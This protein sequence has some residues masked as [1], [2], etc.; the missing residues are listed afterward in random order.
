MKTKFILIFVSIFGLN[1]TLIKSQ[2]PVDFSKI[3]DQRINSDPSV[4]W[5]QFG[6]GG[7]GNNYYIYWHPTDPNTV[8][9]G[10]N[11]LNA[12]RS[13]DGG[14]TYQGILDYDGKG[15]R[16]FERGPIMITT[17]EFSYQNPDFGFCTTEDRN[18]L[19]RTNDKGATWTLTDI[20]KDYFENIF[21]NTI[22]VDPTDGNIW[23]A[24]SGSIHDCNHYFHTHALP[25]GKNSV[26]KNHKARIWKSIDKGNSWTNITPTGINQDA[27]IT[28]I[29]VHPG[30]PS[31]VF[32]ATTYG[33]Y[34]S[35]NGG[36]S[37]TLKTKTGMDNDIIRS[38]D[39][40][41][42]KITN[43]LT[44]YAIDLVKYIP[45]G[46]SLTYNGGIYKSTD[47]GESW[48]NINNNMPLPSSII[49]GY[50]V[51]RSL[52]IDALSGWFGITSTV[53]EATYSSIPTQLLH[54]VSVI[55]VNPSDPNKI[56]VINNYKSQYTFSGGMMWRSDNGGDSWFVTFRNGT[57]WE[58]RDYAVWKSRNNPTS[59]NIT[60]RAQKEWEKRDPYD[61]K[62]GAVAEFNCT[63]DRIMFQVAKVVCISDDNGDTWVENDEQEATPNS[64]NWVGAGNS[65]MPGADIIQDPR[66]DNFIYLTSGENSIW[67]TTSDGTNVRPYAQAVHKIN[68]PNRK[69]P[70]ECSV[71]TIAI[72]PADVNTLYSV[73]FRQMYS[74]L[75]M[76][77]TDAGEN[78]KQYGKVFDFPTNVSNPKLHQQSL[79]IDPDDRK[80]YCCVPYS[81]VNDKVDTYAGSFIGFGVY[82]STDNGVTF[83]QLNN[84]LPIVTDN[85]LNVQQLAL[86]PNNKGVVYAAVSTNTKLNGGLFRLDKGS[87]TWVKVSLPSG[88]AG[89]NNLLFAH[90][91]MYISC[92]STSPTYQSVS[93]GGVWCSEDN[94]KNWTQIF[95]CFNANHIAVA[96]YDPKVILI[97]IPSINMINPGVYRSLNGGV[98]WSKINTGNLQSDRLNALKI[99]LYQRGVYWCSTYGAGYYKGIDTVEMMGNQSGIAPI[100]EN[101]S[102]NRLHTFPN[103]TSGK[104]SM[105]F[106]MQKPGSL[107][108]MVMN[109]LGAILENKNMPNIPSGT[110]N[111]EISL[112]K[113]P[114]GIYFLCLKEGTQ[115][116]YSKINKL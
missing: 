64:E 29:L 75:L 103:P 33:L 105:S 84:G 95:P 15:Y 8:F 10:P 22:E 60:Y 108:Y 113:Y 89:V 19:Y 1:T 49:S 53:A 62:S 27:Q 55:R 52:Y 45:N 109:D 61:Q 43:K 80:F 38:I 110:F 13:T 37:W 115:M 69:D 34:K 98:S 18:F 102:L 58:G 100:V 24:G 96:N 86:D 46:N 97:S 74:G 42:D 20:S 26:I 67:R 17:P 65:N 39:M 68:I 41:F 76:K 36:T 50:D 83:H 59:H 48:K 51:K 11:M 107:Q 111:Y 92:G 94:G 93:S 4:I 91:K 28:A 16:T 56:L 57:N 112:E 47:E 70:D 63:G 104:F 3:D 5:R 116:Y 72:D 114:T 82:R 106:N 35:T 25:H 12:Y 44:L 23:Y 30:N 99:D 81:A 85:K 21:I 40:H 32:A 78:W 66:L 6:P 54:S 2:T 90:N 31:I 73:Q 7:S 77:S 9:H 79:I 14:N 101:K 71:S 87:S 88:I